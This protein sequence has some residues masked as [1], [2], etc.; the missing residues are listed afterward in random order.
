MC[1]VCSMV[2]SKFSLLSAVLIFF[3]YL[4]ALPKSR[5]QFNEHKGMTKYFTW[6]L[7]AYFPRKLVAIKLSHF[8]HAIDQIY[9]IWLPLWCNGPLSAL[10]TWH[11]VF[12]SNNLKN[13]C[14]KFSDRNNVAQD[15]ICPRLEIGLSP[16][17]LV[18]LVSLTNCWKLCLHL[19]V[20]SHEDPFCFMYLFNYFIAQYGTREGVSWCN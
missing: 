7:K 2:S 14:F 13:G 3:L 4:F 8:Q 16:V 9:Y 11:P 5:I 20:Y 17:I 12:D 18:G 6:V 19:Q 1:S 10:T 15:W